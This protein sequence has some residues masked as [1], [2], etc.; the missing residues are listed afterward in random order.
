[1]TKLPRYGF[2]TFLHEARLDFAMLFGSIY[3]LIEGG[4]AWSLDALVT[5]KG[6]P[7]D[8]TET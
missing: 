1:V 4:G 2:W 6:G 8:S 7:H 5:H 3:L